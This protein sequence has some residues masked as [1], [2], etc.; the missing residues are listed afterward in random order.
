[1][2]KF[3]HKLAFAT[4]ILF[5][6]LSMFQ[7]CAQTASP[8][9]GKKDTLAPKIVSS[10]PLNKSKNYTGKKVELNFNEYVNIRNLN[11]ELLITP[12]VGTY[13]TRIRPTGVTLVLDSALHQNTTYTFNFRNAIED[14]SERNIGKNIKLVFSS[15]TDIDSLQISGQVKHLETNKKLESILVGL[16]PFTDT[17]RID[18]AKPYY[19]TKTDTSGNYQIENIA[20]GK[21][22]M[23]A[24]HDINNNLVYNSNKEP[25]DF[26]T[27]NY[28]DLIKSQTQDFKIAL[29]NQDPLKI[30]KTTSTAKTVLYELSRGVKR[31]DIEPKTLAYQIESN[32]NLRFYVGNVEHQDTVRIT[33]TVTDSLNR[34]A[35]ISLKLKF[36]EPNKKEKVVNA[37]LRIEVLP[38][39]NHLLSPEDSI[40]I[41]FPKP[42]V[43]INTKAISF[44]TGPDEEIQL[45]DEAYRWNSF[46][47]EL[48]IQK[49]YLPLRTK[50]DLKFSKHAFVSVEKDSS[51]TFT[52]SF[53]FQDLENYGSI[54][55]QI[56]SPEGTHIF[57]LIKS[58]TKVL[59]YQQTGLNS[60]VF[61]HVE[62]GLYELRAIEDRNGN[63][64]WDLGNFKTKEKPESVYFFT[65][66]IKLKANFQI[67]DVLISAQ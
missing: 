7:R 47:N 1:M 31:I 14:M 36:R 12:N 59:A 18:Q 53:E 46:V 2:P 35:T 34:I 64:V 55:G 67:T 33:A 9:G 63:G 23:A 17:L 41:K 3:L 51:Q 50:F 4:F 61:P 19:F 29:Q 52:Q 37:P 66:K 39:S 42:I 24:F 6:S 27:E 13:E 65:G 15:G 49:S 48:S 11:Q 5:L 40:V 22:Y 20:A 32:R 57:Q 60:F 26:I 38:A 54:S 28:I 10:I 30:S 16:Y 62:P 43:L 58:D 56:K 44:V 25:V 45:P 8:P 21:Y